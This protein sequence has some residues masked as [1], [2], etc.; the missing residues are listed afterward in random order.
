MHFYSLAG[1]ALT[2]PVIIEVQFCQCVIAVQSL[3]KGNCPHVADLVVRKVQAEQAAVAG[4][5]FSN[6]LNPYSTTSSSSKE[7]G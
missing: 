6:Q 3:S 4:E 5:P 7:A 2:Y 1:T